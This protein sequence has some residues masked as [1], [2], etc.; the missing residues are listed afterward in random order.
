MRKK[1][2]RSRGSVIYPLFAGMFLLLAAGYIGTVTYFTGFD[3][4]AGWASLVFILFMLL[5]GAIVVWVMQREAAATV[6]VISEIM[7]GAISGRPR[8]TGYTENAASSLENKVTRFVELA[9]IHEQ[10]LE[11][12]KGRIKSLI[13]DI[14]HQTKTP[15]SNIILYVGLLEETPELP[16]EARQYVE[17]VK[18]QSAKLEWLIR[19]LVKMSRLETGMIAIKQDIAPVVDTITGAVSQIYAAAEQ[20]GIGVLIECDSSI[21]ARHDPKWTAEALFNLMEN[22]VKYGRPSGGSLR[23]SVHANEMFTRIDIAD[24][25]IGIPEEERNDIFKR[26]Y[27]GKGT[28]GYEGVGIGLYLTREIVSAQGGYVKVTSVPDEGSTFS[29]FLPA[30]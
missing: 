14:S 16:G 28:A 3:T 8:Q 23:V 11:A 26:F 12:E 21:T 2:G 7:D 18:D 29:V 19:S 10:K 20:K 15:L 22:A 6:E 27:R 4:A 5:L 9:G 24:N 1:S 30:L 17:S 13:S 25:G